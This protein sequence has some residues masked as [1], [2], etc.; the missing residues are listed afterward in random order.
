M[1]MF[2]NAIVKENTKHQNEGG[3][4]KEIV[5]AKIYN[6]FI[7]D[8]SI[9]VNVCADAQGNCTGCLKKFGEYTGQ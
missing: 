7:G 1:S 2:Y 9:K 8:Q 5:V 4:L 6:G 3:N